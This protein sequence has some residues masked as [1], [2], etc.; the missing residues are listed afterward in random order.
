MLH[1]CDDWIGFLESC[2]TWIN[3][4]N[5]SF[6]QRL[7][8]YVKITQP[9]QQFN[10]HLVCANLWRGQNVSSVEWQWNESSNESLVVNRWSSRI[11]AVS[12]AGV[13]SG[14][15]HTMTH[16]TEETRPS[17]FSLTTKLSVT[18]EVCDGP[19]SLH[20]RQGNSLPSPLSGQGCV[21]GGSMDTTAGELETFIKHNCKG[22]SQQSYFPLNHC[23]CSKQVWTLRTS[24]F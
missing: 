24:Y 2:K 19:A 20:V 15:N 5:I 21:I 11:W 23:S 16:S 22:H 10:T 9:V 8:I 14:V 17:H 6:F 4:K 13:F 18:A 3:W 12:A 7:A 1:N